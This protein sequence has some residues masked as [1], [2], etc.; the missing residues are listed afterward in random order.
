LAQWGAPVADAVTALPDLREASLFVSLSGAAGTASALGPKA[1]ETR[2]ALAEALN[3]TNPGR[4]WHTDRGPILHIANWMGD[5]VAALAGMGQGLVGL[6]GSDT[7]EIRLGGAGASSTMPQKQNPV[8][9]SVLVALNNQMAGL[10]ASLQAASAHQFQRD[11]VAWF[12]EW[13]VLPQIALCTAAALETACG[14]AQAMEPD[15]ARMAA[16]VE[17][18][19]LIHAEALSFALAARMPRPKAQARTKEL[20]AEAV[21]TTT[22][23]SE[24]AHAAEPDLPPTLF[25]SAAQLGNAPSDAR[26][27][28]KRVE[29]L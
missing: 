16:H 24:I 2:A 11:G 21:R 22:P 27:F 13:M 6:A 12:T 7:C 14:L 17:G 9:P 8:G 15:T 23:L 25:Q 10:R 28:A 20:V 5:M 29:T 18:L 1:A 4:S 3:L 19:G 26:A